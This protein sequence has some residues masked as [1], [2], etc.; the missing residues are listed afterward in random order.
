MLPLLEIFVADTINARSCKTAS[1]TRRSETGNRCPNASVQELFVSGARVH[2]YIHSHLGHDVRSQ[3]P[4]QKEL[5][6]QR[7][8]ED[9]QVSLMCNLLGGRMETSMEGLTTCTFVKDQLQDARSCRRVPR[10]KRRKDLRIVT[11]AYIVQCTQ[12][13]KLKWSKNGR[14]TT[15][16]NHTKPC[17]R[18]NALSSGQ[19]FTLI[20]KSSKDIIQPAVT[21]YSH[22][23]TIPS[24][25]NAFIQKNITR[26]SQQNAAQTSSAVSHTSSAHGALGAA[27][28]TES[29][30]ACHRTFAARLAACGARGTSALEDGPAARCCRS[31]CSIC[32]KA[33]F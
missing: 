2:T 18:P 21:L 26:Y 31:G 15:H 13:N 11:P 5:A 19:Y 20:T 14:I 1:D 7:H 24:P 16:I 6:V 10:M 29:Q 27:L 4:L 17:P 25:L 8:K 33:S 9:A 12:P 3:A 30:A 22:S 23:M 28:L 32:S